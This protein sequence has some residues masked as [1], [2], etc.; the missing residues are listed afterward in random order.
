MT[1]TDN[2]TTEQR[3]AYVERLL[4]RTSDLW[5]RE[6]PE[7]IGKEPITDELIE[8]DKVLIIKTNEYIEGK[9]D[10]D[11]LNKHAVALIAGWRKQF[12]QYL[13]QVPA[14]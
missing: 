1:D 9:I 8:M 4:K 2:L 7:G 6:A 13:Q 14:T 12:G 10:K 11:H 5:N 3:E